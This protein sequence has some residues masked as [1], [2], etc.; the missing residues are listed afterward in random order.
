MSGL[1]GTCEQWSVSMR[2]LGQA[3]LR[4]VR[5]ACWPTFGSCIFISKTPP[6]ISFFRTIKDNSLK[7]MSDNRDSFMNFCLQLT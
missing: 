3:R 6:G 7:F 2:P 5:E 4:R 1:D